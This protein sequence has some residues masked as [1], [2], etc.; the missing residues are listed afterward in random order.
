MKTIES[1]D[2][3]YEILQRVVR[4]EAALQQ[5]GFQFFN[6]ALRS[7]K[8]NL[9]KE[10]QIKGLLNKYSERIRC[11]KDLRFPHRKILDF[12]LTQYDFSKNEFKEV[13][14]SRLVREARLGKNKAKSYLSLLEQ[15]GYVKQR[16]DG[17]RKLFSILQGDC[18]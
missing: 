7:Y 2:Y 16:N 15:K 14:F 1:V 13:H 12:L 6:N 4:I 10:T 5:D 18:E 17:Y 11:D 9:L 8:D 3:T